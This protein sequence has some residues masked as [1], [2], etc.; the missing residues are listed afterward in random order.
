VMFLIN[1]IYFKGTW[2][3]SFN[4]S[5]TKPAP[6]TAYDGTTATVPLMSQESRFRYAMASGY[7]AVD[8]PYGNSAFTMTVVLPQQGADINTFVEGMTQEKWSSIDASM[9]E[10]ETGLALP[11]F[12]LTWQRELNEDLSKLGMGV[13]FT[14]AADFTRM[15]TGGDRLLITKVVQKTFVDVNE[16]GTEAAAVTSVGVG[17]T[18]GPPT[19]RVDRPFLFAIRERLSGT[20]LFIGKIQKFPL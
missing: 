19:I 15:S 6:F 5:D 8:L 13:A 20:I 12:K 7:T 3:N 17:P 1:A 18:S 9:H 10:G 14:E 11:R 4:K 2:V 16:E